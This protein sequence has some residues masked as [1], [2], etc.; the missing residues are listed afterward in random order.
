MTKK[1]LEDE[2]IKNF[3]EE[4]ELY[5][6]NKISFEEKKKIFHDYF[7]NFPFQYLTFSNL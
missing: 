6:Q 2:V 4:W 3:G 7:A 1:N 5:N